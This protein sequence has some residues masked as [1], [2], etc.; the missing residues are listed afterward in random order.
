MLRLLTTRCAAAAMA[1][2]KTVRAV[3]HSLAGAESGML[4]CEG[5]MKRSWTQYRH[6]CLL[7]FAFAE[8]CGA[9]PSSRCQQ[10]GQTGVSHPM[11][12][13]HIH[14]EKGDQ[15]LRQG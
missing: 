4:E 1:H 15:V 11:T 2:S 8:G 14:A 9:A 5:P 12:V 10:S 3:V 7:E 6:V 13:V